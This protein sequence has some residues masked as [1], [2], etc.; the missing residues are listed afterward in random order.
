M[1]GSAQWLATYPASA[2]K[3]QMEYSIDPAEQT[4]DVKAQLAAIT[5]E[6]LNPEELTLIDPACGS[7]HVLVE[8]YEL[9]KAIEARQ[10]EQQVILELFNAAGDYNNQTLELRLERQLDGVA[11]LVPY[12]PVPFKIVEL[13][14]Q[15]P[16]GS[17]F[18]HF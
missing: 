10:W 8:A 5:P 14:L 3:G 11:T 18:D 9:F 16:L 15:R 6:A 12:K 1:P 17:D 7:G 4:D 2:L 13:K